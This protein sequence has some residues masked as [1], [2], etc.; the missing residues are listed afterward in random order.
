MKQNE[1][2]IEDL[3]REIEELKNNWKRALADYQ[4]LEKRVALEK[5]E[6]VAWAT[7][8]LI[9]KLLP[10]LDS[11]KKAEEQLK[12]EGVKLAVKQLEEALKEEGLTKI[13][14]LGKEFTPATMECLAAVTGKKEDEGK[15]AEEIR[16][17]YNFKG[18]VLRA[19]QVTVYKFK[20][21]KD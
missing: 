8:D 1:T 3:K 9:T 10:A 2:Q 7:A 21:D 11:L 12:D 5:Q 15:V 18:R 4:N 17:G 13:E 14:V 20:G 19:A 16:T 6:F